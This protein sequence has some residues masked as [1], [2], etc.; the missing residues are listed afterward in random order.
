[1]KWW[2]FVRSYLPFVTTNYSICCIVRA[3]LQVKY[4]T[5]TCT[6]T[7]TYAR[8]SRWKE[9]FQML[10][11]SLWR[12]INVPTATK[13]P[14]RKK[15]KNKHKIWRKKNQTILTSP[16]AMAIRRAHQSDHYSKSGQL[17]YSIFSMSFTW[18]PFRFLR[19]FQHT[20]KHNEPDLWSITI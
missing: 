6:Y 2:Y 7:T 1:M 3:M 20:H 19:L 9:Y 5:F 10:H 18:T 11:L 4:A 15:N 13:L 12:V 14:H 8:Q 16:S 17:L